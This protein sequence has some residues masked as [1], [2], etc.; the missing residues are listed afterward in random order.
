MKPES[1][2][3]FLAIFSTLILVYALGALSIYQLDNYGWS[4]FILIPFLVG[5]VPPLII[6]QRRSLTSK[7]AAHLG[8][9]TL[10][11]ATLAMLL[12]ALE[13]LICIAMASPMLIIATWLGSYLAFLTSKSRFFNGTNTTII[14]IVVSIGCMSFDTM[15][16]PKEL[17]PVRTKVVVNAP[18]EK[19]WNYVVSFDS[20]PEP[21]DW[22]FKT[23][24]SYPTNATIEGKGV[25]AIRYCNFST[26]SFVEPI[27]TWEEPHL[28]QFDVAE[29]PIP[30]NELNPFWEVHPPH[31]E[32]YFKSQ[33]G[34]FKLHMISNNQTELEGTTW[35]QMD[36]Y[37]MLYW[38][39][40]SDFIIHR[41]HNRVLNH[42]KEEA[43]GS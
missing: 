7:Q 23:G 38:R 15:E 26:G 11:L 21:E 19:V 1:K 18:I 4:V 24:I 2:L 13:G 27:T 25:G 12:F 22:I 43:Q 40:W 17:I 3:N 29:Q 39:I 37:P 35:Y 34:Q 30:M 31:L 5:F 32:G 20:I 8:F 6:L 42:I 41:I 33:R 28:L 10:G 14:L 9:I 16:K 36:L